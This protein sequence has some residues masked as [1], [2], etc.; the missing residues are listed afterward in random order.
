MLLLLLTSAAKESLAA[1]KELWIQ[2]SAPSENPIWGFQEGI[3]IGLYPS[4]IRGLIHV[5]AP[6]AGQ[7]ELQVIN[8][9]AIEPVIRGDIHR[10]FSELEP[11]TLDNLPGKRIWSADTDADATPR[12]ACEATRGV[13][14]TID[15]VE[16]LTLFLF[17]EPFANGAQV[18]VR[19]RFYADRPHE[20]ELSTFHYGNSAE[21]EHCIVTATMGNYARLRTLWL[22]GRTLSASRVWPDYTDN[23]FAPHEF[24]PRSSMIRDHWGLPYFIASPDEKT[25]AK[26]HYHPQLPAWWHYQGRKATQYWC[27]KTPHEG[28]LGIVNG[29]VVYWGDLL[30]IPGGISYENFELRQPYTAGDRFVFGVTPLTPKTFIKTIRK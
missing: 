14:Q 26:A 30:P 3:R 13:T 9:I 8:F 19:V 20:F 18:Y 27:C 16:T 28:L 17:V 23:G 15:G 2:P 22:D 25:P 24:I 12:A 1:G 7:D 21:L 10:G 29:R 4:S 6:Y 5:Y 11:S